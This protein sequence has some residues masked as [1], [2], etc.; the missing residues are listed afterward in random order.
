M[1]APGNT[2]VFSLLPEMFPRISGARV[3]VTN[4][5]LEVEAAYL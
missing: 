3:V 2:I 1:K 5:R 4:S